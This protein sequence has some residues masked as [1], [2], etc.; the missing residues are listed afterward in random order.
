MVTFTEE[1]LNGK[2]HFLCSAGR[3]L[4]NCSKTFMNKILRC[5]NYSR[6]A[7]FNVFI[8][9]YSHIFVGKYNKLIHDSFL[10]ASTVLQK[11]TVFSTNFLVSKFFGNKK[12]P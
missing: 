10:E 3:L 9:S 5:G 12:L 4:G 11:S 1:I 7:K 8:V 6:R 2:L